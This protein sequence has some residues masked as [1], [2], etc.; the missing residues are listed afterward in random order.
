MYGGIRKKLNAKCGGNRKI[1]N[2][3]YGGIRKILNAEYGF[4]CP[5]N[6][7]LFTFL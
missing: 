2:A 7:T 6:T 5:N 3:K 4:Y 1:L